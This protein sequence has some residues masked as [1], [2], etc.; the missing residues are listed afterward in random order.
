[1]AT[2]LIQ[3]FQNFMQRHIIPGALNPERPLI[4]PA[5]VRL[6]LRVPLIGVLPARLI[7]FGPRAVHVFFNPDFNRR[8]KVGKGLTSAVAPAGNI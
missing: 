6:L 2:R 4:I 3:G 8:W 7:A 1:M 5:W